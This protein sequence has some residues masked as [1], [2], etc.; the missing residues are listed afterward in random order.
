MVKFIRNQQHRCKYYVTY[1]T[2]THKH[3]HIN[4]ISNLMY[5]HI[6]HYYGIHTEHR[7]TAI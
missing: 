4:H 2:Q 7:A 6:E 1:Y 3:L 5:V